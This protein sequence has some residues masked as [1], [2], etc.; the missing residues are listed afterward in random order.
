MVEAWAIANNLQD[1]PQLRDVLSAVR[2][3]LMSTRELFQVVRPTGYVESNILLD[4]IQ[5]QTNSRDSSLR[6]RGFL[7]K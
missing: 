2:F 5:I 7:C 6:Y 4:A 1:T 3:E